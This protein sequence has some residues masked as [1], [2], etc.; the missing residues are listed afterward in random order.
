MIMLRSKTLLF[1]LCI[2]CLMQEALAI[3]IRINDFRYSAEATK[4][5]LVFD[6]S[7]PINYT[8]QERPNKIVVNIKD[9]KLICPLNKTWLYKTPVK[10]VK[11][12][13]LGKDLRLTLNLKEQIKL[14]H[15]ALQKPYRLALDLLETKTAPPMADINN[16]QLNSLEEKIIEEQINKPYMAL[17][18]DNDQTNSTDE[19][20]TE[21]QINNSHRLNKKL[22]DVVI[23]IDPGH[24]GTDPGAVGYKGAREKDIA[25]AVAKILQNTINK[26]K[27]FRAVLTRNSDYF[28]TLRQRL[29][30]AHRYKADMFIAIHADAYKYKSSHG[31]SVFALSQR[32]A[33]SEAA[34]WLAEKENESELG[35]TISD[36]NALLRS[37]LIDLAQAATIHASLEAG[38]AMLQELGHISHLHSHR[39]EQAAFVVLKS[40]DIPSLLVEI[41][42]ISDPYEEGRLCDIKYQQKIAKCLATGAVE[43]FMHRPPQGTYL[44]DKYK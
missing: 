29:D 22:R 39:V 44:K 12:S 43:Y 42:F 16:D 8:I 32:G 38:G 35:Q 40:P 9:A 25:L 18:V 11:S 5:R 14:Q 21:E 31:A 15:F 3:S 34:R 6:A 24:G 27:G 7:G 13:Q 20:I 28:I 36:K 17:A 4:I 41:G 33:T 19:I 26:V 10:S 2:L 1:F 30:I 23:V 37:V